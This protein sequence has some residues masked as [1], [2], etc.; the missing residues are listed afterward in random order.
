MLNISEQ[1]FRI[2]QGIRCNRHKGA[3][4]QK[5]IPRLF[6]QGSEQ[7]LADTGAIGLKLRACFRLLKLRIVRFFRQIRHHIPFQYAEMRCCPGGAG[8]ST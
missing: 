1:L 3:V 2:G 7:H 6:R 5:V 4:S 8:Q